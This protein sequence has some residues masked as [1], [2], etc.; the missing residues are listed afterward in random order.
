MGGKDALTKTQKEIFFIF[1]F[2]N[3]FFLCYNTQRQEQ[4]IFVFV[5][6]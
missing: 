5:F 1:L 3:D 6:N 2:D 4:K